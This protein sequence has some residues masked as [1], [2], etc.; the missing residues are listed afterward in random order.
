MKNDGTATVPDEIDLTTL[1]YYEIKGG[2]VVDIIAKPKKA[3]L[4]INIDSI[5]D[6]NYC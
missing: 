2:E 5:E 4:V 1:I 6:G 3:S